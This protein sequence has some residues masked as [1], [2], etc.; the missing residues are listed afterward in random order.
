M[1]NSG[2]SFWEHAL[3]PRNHCTSVKLATKSPDSFNLYFSIGYEF[4]AK[5]EKLPEETEHVLAE[6]NQIYIK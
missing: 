4:C 2:E 5:V 6:V 1:D 3:K